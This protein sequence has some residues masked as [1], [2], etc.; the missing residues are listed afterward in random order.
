MLFLPRGTKLVDYK[1]VKVALGC[2]PGRVNTAFAV[3]I[4]GKGLVHTSVTDGLDEI[5]QILNFRKIF[6]RVLKNYKPDCFCIERFHSQPGRGSKKN[7]EKINLLIGMCIEAC[8][9]RKI[10][11]ELVTASVHK[12]WIVKEHIVKKNT[13]LATTRRGRP[14]KIQT[15]FD[16][17]SY[18]EWKDF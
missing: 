12:R 10:P 5:D 16:T 9:Q 4:R 14:A 7:M 13:K 11:V 17:H 3:Y 8:L 18:K 6:L 15:K 2:D 1:N